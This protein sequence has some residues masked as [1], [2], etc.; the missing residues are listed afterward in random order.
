[1]KCITNP[2]DFTPC[3]LS[4]GEVPCYQYQKTLK[5]ELAAGLTKEDAL[6]MHR[7]MLYNRAFE[8]IIVKLR[9]GE[10]VQ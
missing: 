2:P 8:T 10:L 5:D 9:S 3:K 1:M 4:F 7:L 6:F